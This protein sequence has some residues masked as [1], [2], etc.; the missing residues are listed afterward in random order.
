[1]GHNSPYE[2]AYHGVPVV[3]FPLFGDQQVVAEKVEDFGL[4]LN[5][6]HKR[7]NAQQ[8]FETIQLIISE[9][10]YSCC[11]GFILSHFMLFIF[12]FARVDMREHHHIQTT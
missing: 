11:F 10:R 5:V 3:A 8:L 4:G 12:K 1:M 2:S 6:D 7:T 9:P